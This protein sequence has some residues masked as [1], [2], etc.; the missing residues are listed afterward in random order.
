M[1]FNYKFFRDLLINSPKREIIFKF[2]EE[3]KAVN[4]FIYYQGYSKDKCKR[5]VKKANTQID[6]LIDDIA[7]EFVTGDSQKRILFNKVLN[8]YKT[9]TT[10]HLTK[11][12]IILL[13]TKT[14]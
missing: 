11:S 7:F 1:K 6:L 8:F 13:K 2:D 3:E 9:E 10:L 12:K 14:L 4:N 5:E